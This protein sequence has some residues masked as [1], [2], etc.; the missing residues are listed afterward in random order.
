MKNLTH[1]DIRFLVESGKLMPKRSDD[2]K[3]IIFPGKPPRVNDKHHSGCGSHP[4]GY[5]VLNTC[6]VIDLD[7][8]FPFI[9]MKDN[10]KKYLMPECFYHV[11]N[12]D[13]LDSYNHLEEKF[14]KWG[15]IAKIYISEDIKDDSI[16]DVEIELLSV[17]RDIYADYVIEKYPDL[18]IVSKDFFELLN[19]DNLYRI[20]LHDN[21]NVIFSGLTSLESI[22]QYIFDNVIENEHNLF[23]FEEDIITKFCN[24]DII[25]NQVANIRVHILNFWSDIIFHKYEKKYKNDSPILGHLMKHLYSYKD[26]YPSDIVSLLYWLD[27]YDISVLKKDLLFFFNN[28]HHQE[29]VETIG[30]ILEPHNIPSKKSSFL[31]VQ[32][33]QSIYKKTIVLDINNIREKL[34]SSLL[35]TETLMAIIATSF[36]QDEKNYCDIIYEINV[37]EEFIK[38]HIEANDKHTAEQLSK[39]FLSYIESSMS[40]LFLNQDI[41]RKLI[42]H[43]KHTTRTKYE[44]DAYIMDTYTQI[45]NKFLLNAQLQDDLPQSTVKMKN[46]KI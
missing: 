2:S 35:G 40:P 38:F 5:P 34:K 7:N 14:K 25:M 10:T 43:Q 15:N 17:F 23:K 32:P 22:Y 1:Q 36:K 39:N 19:N 33:T 30:K 9:I 28:V 18:N 20:I 42:N 41:I 26:K 8:I 16:S 37:D 12:A 6:N 4:A 11:F 46:N 13:N 27:V 3:S 31:Y 45:K 44:Q 24:N 21:M 29:F